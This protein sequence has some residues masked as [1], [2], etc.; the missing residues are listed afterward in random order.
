MTDLETKLREK[1]EKELEQ[2]KKARIENSNTVSASQREN[3][4]EQPGV[5]S[6]DSASS[7]SAASAIPAI[8]VSAPSQEELPKPVESLKDKDE[9]HGD[10]VDADSLGINFDDSKEF[11]A[12]D[13]IEVVPDVPAKDIVEDVPEVKKAVPEDAPAVDAA[14]DK[15]VAKKAPKPPPPLPTKPDAEA[16]KA[17][18]NRTAAKVPTGVNPKGKKKTGVGTKAARTT[19]RR[20]AT[21]NKTNVG[22]KGKRKKATQGPSATRS[23][24]EQEKKL[25][26]ENNRIDEKF[27]KQ[28]LIAYISITAGTILL[29][30]A[31]ILV[32]K[33]MRDKRRQTPTVVR[34]D[35]K[36]NGKTTAKAKPVAKYASIDEMSEAV[37]RMLRLEKDASKA[38][39]T[40]MAHAQSRPEDATQCEAMIEGVAKDYLA[41]GKASL[42]WKNMHTN[43]T[44]GLTSSTPE[45]ITKSII[46]LR[47]FAYRNSREAFLA[48]YMI[49]KLEK[50]YASMTGG[51]LP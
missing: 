20:R 4:G 15:S 10:D 34:K 46:A 30:I 1:I 13:A 19:E 42:S 25:L 5:A 35:K 2:R 29:L 8:E 12:V 24:N 31:M 32:L 23:L 14:P 41:S 38:V 39:K 49:Q 27:K 45:D 22:I 36:S 47:E 40:I 3:N 7:D 51:L 11:P 44:L 26:Q 28:K 21:G 33:H 17:K 9:D 16:P 50:R 43:L 6:S 37:D 48:E 18:K